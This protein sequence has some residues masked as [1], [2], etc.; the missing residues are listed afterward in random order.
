MKPLAIDLFCG[1]GGWTNG[2]QAAGWQVIGFDIA[3]MGGYP[4]ELVLQDVLTLHGAQFRKADLIVASPPCQ[5]Y[6][7]MAMPWK[8]AKHLACWYR[9]NKSRI[10]E[11]T[12]LFDACFRIQREACEAAG[13]HIPMVLENV[14]GAQP[15]VGAA[16]AHYGS[17]YLWGDVASIGGAIVAGRMEFGA[18]VLRAVKAQKFNPDGTDHGPGS[19]FKIADSKERGANTP[20]GRKVPGF[21]FHQHEKTGEP[22][23]SF[24][25]AATKIP[26]QNW[27]R[28]SE[29]GEVSPH[30]NAQAING[31]KGG[32]GGWFSDADA[33]GKRP[34]WRE[35]GCET[36]KYNSRSAARKEA[37]ARIAMIPPDLALHIGRAFYPGA[38]AAESAETCTPD[39]AV[40]EAMPVE[41]R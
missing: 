26:G 9:S 4:G 3:D 41:H 27:S 39:D 12:A 29:T 25:T 2:L 7:Y 22:G 17:F 23:G 40:R 35:S 30:W 31:R 6:S 13:R 10:P 24:Q 32:G 38:R 36:R 15:W 19:W 8:R 1:K 37:S 18:P 16:K 5:K 14:K 20:D 21:N 34:D 28:F 11:L 33:D